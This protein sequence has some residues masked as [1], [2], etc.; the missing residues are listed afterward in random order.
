MHNRSYIKKIIFDSL[1]GILLFVYFPFHFNFKISNLIIVFLIT[2]ISDNIDVKWKNHNR[3]VSNVPGFLIAYLYGPQ[4]IF[5]A[6]LITLFRLNEINSLRRIRKF[7][8][9][10][11][12]YYSSYVIVNFFDLNIYTKLFLYISLSKIINSLMVDIKTFGIKLFIIEYIFFIASLPSIYLYLLSQ[13]IIVKYYFL[14]QN[15]LFLGIYYFITKYIYEKEEEEI[16]NKRLNRFNAIMLEFSNLLYSYSIKASKE[17][18]LK[19]AAKFLNEKFGYKYILI[20]E[21]DYE[22]D[23]IKR[24]SYSGFSSEEFKKLKARKVKASEIINEVFKDN[25]RYGE[26][27]FIPNIAERLDKNDYFYLNKI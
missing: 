24:V 21:F 11:F 8:V 1:I 10:F 25:Y 17:F 22:K 19:E 26:V 18:I 5:A 2:F 20:S 9:Y 6:S 12:M 4:Y 7:L 3:L 15:L 13:N 16:K 23:L 27:Y 14:F